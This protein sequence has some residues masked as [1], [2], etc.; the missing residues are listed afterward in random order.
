LLLP[1]AFRSGDDSRFLLLAL[2]I[3]LIVLAALWFQA[4]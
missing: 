1:L 3:A 2:P 4:R